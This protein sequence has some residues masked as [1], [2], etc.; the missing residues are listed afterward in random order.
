MIDTLRHLLNGPTYRPSDDTRKGNFLNR[1]IRWRQRRKSA[2]W[3]RSM[4]DYLLKDIGISRGEIEQAT[5]SRHEAFTLS[6]IVAISDDPFGIS[7][8]SKKPLW[9]SAAGADDK[10]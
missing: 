3:L 8:R 5:R 9:S 4:P 1:F 10:R 6:Q 2:E 7:R